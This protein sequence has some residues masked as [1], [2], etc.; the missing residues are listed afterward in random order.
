VAEPR[1]FMAQAIVDGIPHGTDTGT[2]TLT[3]EQVALKL[4]EEYAN[5]RQ[6]GASRFEVVVVVVP[7]GGNRG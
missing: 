2:T 5:D 4:C 7:K 3:A 1:A 6:V